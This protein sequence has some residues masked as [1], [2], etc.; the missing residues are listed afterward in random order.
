MERDTRR[1]LG[2]ELNAH[3]RALPDLLCSGN[4][5]GTSEAR[6]QAAHARWGGWQFDECECFLV[7]VPED[8][9]LARVPSRS[10]GPF[11]TLDVVDG[12]TLLGHLNLWQAN[13][14]IHSVDYMPFDAS[15]E[16][17]P[18]LEQIVGGP[19]GWRSRQQGGALRWGP[20]RANSFPRW[21]TLGLCP[22][23]HRHGFLEAT[24]RG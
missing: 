7:D 24:T 14:V 15:D 13:G 9:N 11:A 19:F 3:E 17:L 20:F 16:R 23:P 2:D 18:V 5:R 8:L 10:G 21:G 4:W 1:M 12:D 22:N 6:Q